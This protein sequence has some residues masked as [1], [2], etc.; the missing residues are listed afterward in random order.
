MRDQFSSLTV[1]N[2][3]VCRFT[4]L[5]TF[6]FISFL[7]FFCKMSTTF[8]SLHKNKINCSFDIGVEMERKSHLVYAIKLY[9]FTSHFLFY[10]V[11]CLATGNMEVQYLSQVKNEQIESKKKNRIENAIFTLPTDLCR[12]FHF[13]VSFF[14]LSL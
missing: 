6:Y 14:S 1:R 10:L 5:F 11:R 3:T 9:F 7:F 2:R 4:H 13:Y 8:M 12:C